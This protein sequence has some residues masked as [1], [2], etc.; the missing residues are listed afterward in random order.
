MSGG[1]EKGRSQRERMELIMASLAPAALGSVTVPVAAAGRLAWLAP[2]LALPFGLVL[3]SLWKELGKESLSRGLEATFGRWL[4][5]GAVGAYLLWGVFLLSVSARRCADRLTATV[6]QG[7]SR[8]LVLAATLAVTLWLSRGSDGAS[9]A[10][11][12]RIFFL[13]VTAVLVA[14][15]LLALS[16]LRWEN[17]WP[18]RRVE[19]AGLPTAGAAVLSLAGYGVYALCLPLK[20]GSRLQSET[21]IAW[22]CGGLA[23]LLLAVVGA[24]GPAL[25]QEMDE[26]ILYLLRGVGLPGAF[27][28]GEAALAAVIALGDLAL[29]ALLEWSCGSLGRALI[30][31]WTWGR[32]PMGVLCFLIAGILPNRGSV[33]FLSEEVAPMGNM[34]FGVL[35]PALAVLTKTIQSRRAEQTISCGEDSG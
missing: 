30:P 33:L 24:F 17:L 21:W 16:S 13:A 4:G 20:K 28:R 3:C 29:L 7:D 15:L 25:V 5:K 1:A 18:V 32:Y 26:P 23:A 2:V 14:V 8:W 9:F 11:T 27:Q 31:R 10:R 12:G 34:F 6:G 35:L 22:A 19:A